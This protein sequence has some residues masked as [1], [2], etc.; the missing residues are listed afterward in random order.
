M[1]SNY[2]STKAIDNASN[3]TTTD[4]TYHVCVIVCVFSVFH[5]GKYIYNFTKPLHFP[6]VRLVFVP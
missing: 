6:S 4:S 1:I 2:K 3:A 5:W